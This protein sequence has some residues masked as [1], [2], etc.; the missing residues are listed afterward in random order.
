MTWMMCTPMHAWF[1]T[2]R[3]SSGTRCV[4]VYCAEEDQ[5][6]A[7]A[8]CD[9]GRESAE[10]SQPIVAGPLTYQS[11]RFSLQSTICRTSLCSF[12]CGFLCCAWRKKRGVCGNSV[13]WLHVYIICLDRSWWRVGRFKRKGR[14]IFI[15][16]LNILQVLAIHRT[17]MLWLLGR[18]LVGELD[19][20]DH[21]LTGLFEAKLFRQR[22]Q[23]GADRKNTAYYKGAQQHIR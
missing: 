1:H 17:K 15:C 19:V 22:T 11:S 18:H 16:A 4:C 7:G 23:D 20:S 6:I 10:G 13:S 9:V 5:F 2:A 12:L 21:L 3:H 14:S 8:P